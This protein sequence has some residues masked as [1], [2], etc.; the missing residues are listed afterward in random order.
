MAKIELNN[1]TV[2]QSDYTILDNLS[3]T[4]NSH[5]NMAI[6]G[7][8]GSGKSTLFKIL[9]GQIKYQGSLKINGVEIVKSNIYL[10]KRFISCID[11]SKFN[12]K[13]SIIEELFHNLDGLNL[14]I[15]EEKNRVQ[16]IVDYF[17]LQKDL[18]KRIANLTIQYKNYI[19]V[20]CKL[21]RQS[22]FLVLDD[23]FINMNKEEMKKIITYCFNNGITI[24]NITSEMEEVVYSDYLVVLYN[25]KIAMEGKTKECLKE[26]T[27][28]RRLGFNLPFMVDLSI[29]L[30]YYGL[31]DKIIL[32]EEEMIKKI[33]N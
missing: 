26:E 30:G 27:L 4:L 28:L 7:P 9:N 6:I 33:W 32:N 21:L 14:T 24:I 10:Q 25:K 12:S 8:S 11:N 16:K 15:E 23:V 13:N 20:I 17:N 19:K 29:Q 31:I 1:I 3:L 22:E 2:I 18:D 5:Q